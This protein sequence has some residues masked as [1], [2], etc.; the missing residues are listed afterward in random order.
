MKKL[1]IIGLGL[2]GGSLGLAAK[3]KK[4]ARV[5]CGYARRE[6]TRHEA[7]KL[8][9]VDLVSDSPEEAVKGA[10]MVVLCLPVLAIPELTA[11]CVSHFEENCIV[12]DV[13]STKAELVAEMDKLLKKSKAV[14]VGSHPIA[15]SN[16]TGLSAARGDLYEGAAVVVTPAGL[17]I[18]KAVTAVR[19]M[20]EGLG[21]RVFIM[22]PKDHDKTIARTSH[23][24][25]LVASILV[26][27]VYRNENEAW[28]FCGTGF[29]D[30]TRIAAGSEEIW[31]DILKSN[32]GAVL[33]ELSEF[34]K[35]FKKVNGMVKKSDFTGLRSFLADSRQKRLKFEEQFT[36]ER[37][38]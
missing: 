19:R 6:E 33:Y 34:E 11:V 25:H 23:L 17:K 28:R 3:K 21:S 12:T 14:F 5:V 38:Q 4:V 32:R 9:A 8:G 18:D 24:P 22:R 31:H 20:W 26:N 27:A 29:R 35:V 7:L 36:R 30:A 15:G 13:G 1:A 2:M 37:R 10:D 16:E